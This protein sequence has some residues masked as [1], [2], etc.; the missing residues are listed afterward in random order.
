[1]RCVRITALQRTVELLEGAVMRGARR[2]GA[3]EADD[4]G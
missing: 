4:V 2:E 1:V 3:P